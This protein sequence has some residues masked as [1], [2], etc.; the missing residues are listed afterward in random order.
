M[1]ATGDGTTVRYDPVYTKV[2]EIR[3]DFFEVEGH[4][5][6]VTWMKVYR[7]VHFVK[8]KYIL[9]AHVKKVFAILR[10]SK[11]VISHMEKNLTDYYGRLEVKNN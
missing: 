9:T 1:D 8:L 2:R 4:V 3:I 10:S 6:H 5:V 7:G 11:R